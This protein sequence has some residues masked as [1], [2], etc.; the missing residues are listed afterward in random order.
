M[1]QVSD[2]AATAF[3]AFLAN[4]EGATVIRLELAPM[5]G[6]DTMAAIRFAAVEA[7]AE[8]DIQADAPGV[9][10]FISPE[11]N[12]PLSDAVIDAQATPDGTE[13]VIRRQDEGGMSSGGD[14]GTN[15]SGAQGS[16]MGSDG[17]T[18]AQTQ[19]GRNRMDGS[20]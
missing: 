9:E 14:A 17:D 6:D 10:I 7:P 3:R 11:L 13:L 2:T 20:T 16:P 4:E 19:N 8:G 18:S 12:E 5:P 15:A 1:V